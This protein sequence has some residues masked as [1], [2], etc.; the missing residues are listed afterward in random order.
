MDT[1]DFFHVLLRS[2]DS[3]DTYPDNQPYSFVNTF[4]PDIIFTPHDRVAVSEVIIPLGFEDKIST[5]FSV[6]LH[7]GVG[8]SN[9]TLEDFS[10]ALSQKPKDV[11]KAFTKVSQKKFLEVANSNGA[12]ITHQPS[13]EYDQPEDRMFFKQGEASGGY[14]FRLNFQDTDFLTACGFQPDKLSYFFKQLAP[15]GGDTHYAPRPPSFARYFGSIM[16]ETD[17]IR[18][19]YARKRILRAI[20][21]T[22]GPLNHVLHI[23]FPEK[24]FYPL[25]GNSFGSIRIR[26]LKDNGQLLKIRGEVYVTLLF[27]TKMK[28]LPFEPIGAGRR[29]LPI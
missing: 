24:H 5:K 25:D 4:S 1:E 2:N 26:I 17:L 9:S 20:P 18:S 10:C 21:F 23:T 3:L 14:S 8:E 16:I 19:D 6:G 28:L 29:S 22:N 15:K 13:L 27:K 12:F 11:A 7:Y